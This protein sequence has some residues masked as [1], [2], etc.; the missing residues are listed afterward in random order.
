M[1]KRQAAAAVFVDERKC[2]AGDIVW[3]ATEGFC[4]SYDKAGFART[5]RAFQAQHGV[6]SKA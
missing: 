2:G 5:P 6:A 3:I 4:E 1:D